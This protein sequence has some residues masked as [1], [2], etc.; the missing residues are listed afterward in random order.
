MAGTG[1]AFA[2]RT[3]FES[4]RHPKIMNQSS[5]LLT[6]RNAAMPVAEP[7]VLEVAAAPPSASERLV[8]QLASRI[9]GLGVELADVAG[10]L[11]QVGARGSRPSQRVGHLQKNAPTQVSAH[12]KNA[13]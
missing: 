9:G 12:H 13:T 3:S 5:S 11:R 2:P 8:D 10:N 7:A 6:R 4:Y 1:A